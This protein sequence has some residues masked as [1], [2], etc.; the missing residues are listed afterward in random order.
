MPSFSCYRLLT[1]LGTVVLLSSCQGNS[2][3]SREATGPT[4]AASHDTVEWVGTG[5]Q[6]LHLRPFFSAKLT[7]RPTLVVVLHGD[8]PFRPP[9]YQYTLARQLAAAYPNIIAVGLLR[10]GYTDA[11]GKQSAG[12]RG[13]ATGDN[14]TPADVDAVAAALRGLR[15]RYH[16]NRVLV[17]AHSG[18]AAVTANVLARYPDC[19]DAALLA[20]CPCDVPRWRQHMYQLENGKAIWKT[21]VRSLSPQALVGTVD[22]TVPI[23]LVVGSADSVAPPRFSYAYWQALHQRRSPAKLVQV[24]NEGHELLLSS[25]VRQEIGTLLMSR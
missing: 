7:A 11:R 3:A 24:A 16:V 23:T 15:Q 22:V 12:K 2:R 18:G 19:I 8:A 6:R 20:A 13:E 5:L 14:Y 9:E 17:V 10:P 21:P 25:A 4:A 1:L